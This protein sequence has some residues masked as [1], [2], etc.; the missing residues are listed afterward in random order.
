MKNLLV[1]TFKIASIT[2]IYTIVVMVVSGS[3]MSMGFHFPAMQTNEKTAMFQLL[4]AGFLTALFATYL[5]VRYR[6]LTKM[7]LFLILLF[8]LFLSNISVA[9]EGSLFTPSLITKAVLLT[10]LIQQFFI[11]V[12]VS[13]FAVLLLKNHAKKQT[14]TPHTVK[15]SFHPM[16]MA[17][18][19][20]LCAFTYM[21][22]YYSWGWLN[23]HTFTKPYYDA[24]IAGLA[25]P[26]SAILIKIIFFRGLLITLSI[27]PF[28][29]FIKP[30]SRSKMFEIGAILFVFGGLLP[31]SLMAGTFPLDFI[32]FS[33]IEIL[34]QNFLTGMFI[35]YIFHA[36]G[37][38][39][40][41][42]RK[43]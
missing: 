22:M 26:G 38:R 23:Y 33:L 34:L 41:S 17:I 1:Y 25:V 5:T 28:L 14:V 10:L 19:L 32:A 4:F 43:A 11:A 12:L 20:L 29:L 15:T 21:F 27:V 37:W 9:V 13:V 6:Y 31:L 30:H 42:F 3:L 16:N 18:K 8:V 39:L 2:I 35:Y 36:E 40:L 7:Q 24:G